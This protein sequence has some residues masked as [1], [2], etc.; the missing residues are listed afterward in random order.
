MEETLIQFET[1]K[2]AKEKGF[3]VECLHFYTNPG[4]KM[5]GVDEAAR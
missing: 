3:D 2:L 4:S 1:A 5:Y